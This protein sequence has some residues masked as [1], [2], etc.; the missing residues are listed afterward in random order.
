[1]EI[2]LIRTKGSLWVAEEVDQSA[3]VSRD[4]VKGNE[5][6]WCGVANGLAIN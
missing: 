6:V 3:S 5:L 2:H 4:S 1:V